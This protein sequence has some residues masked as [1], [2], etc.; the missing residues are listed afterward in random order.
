M[1]LKDKILCLQSIIGGYLYLCDYDYSE[2]IDC[3]YE[4]CI[5]HVLVKCPNKIDQIVSYNDINNFIN[6]DEYLKLKDQDRNT[7]ISVEI[8][9]KLWKEFIT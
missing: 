8:V 1:L 6:S 9:I 5:S 2:I 3:S 7:R 4:F